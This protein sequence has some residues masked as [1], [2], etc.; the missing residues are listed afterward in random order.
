MILSNRVSFATNSLVTRA[1]AE[2]WDI[3]YM[4]IL[5]THICNYIVQEEEDIV[6]TISKYTRN[7][8]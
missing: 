2:E 3:L 6:Q 1:L 4:E 7:N 5:E 8:K